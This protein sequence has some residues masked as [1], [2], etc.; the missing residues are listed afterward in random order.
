MPVYCYTYMHAGAIF[1]AYREYSLWL[2][3]RSFCG[4]IF[5]LE[6]IEWKVFHDHWLSTVFFLLY[7]CNGLPCMFN[8]DNHRENQFFQ[9]LGTN[10]IRTAT[11]VSKRT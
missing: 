6:F 8:S 3:K 2:L 4:E 10:S 11:Y 5:R 9:F 1:M 7:T